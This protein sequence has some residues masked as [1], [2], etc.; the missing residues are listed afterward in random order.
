MKNIGL[1][2]LLFAANI[3]I[4]QNDLPIYDKVNFVKEMDAKNMGKNSLFIA[5]PFAKPQLSDIRD[6]DLAGKQ[7]KKI[8]Y[9][10]S[11]NNANPSFGQ[12]ELSNSRYK[13]LMSELSG[14]DLA[15]VE[16]ETKVQ[17]GCGTIP[18]SQKLDHGFIIEFEEESN[19]IQGQLGHHQLENQQKTIRANQANTIKG[20]EGTL[21]KIPENAFVDAFGN[22]VIGNVDINLKEALTTEAIVLANLATVTSNGEILQ[23]KGMIELTAHQNGNEVYVKEGKNIKV[24]VPTEFEEGYSYFEGEQK[25]G[26]L[27]WAN[28]VP[29]EKELNEEAVDNQV[30]VDLI[31]AQG[32]VEFVQNEM[33]ATSS[34][35]TNLKLIKVTVN[36]KGVGYDI[37][38]KSIKNRSFNEETF[39]KAEIDSIQ[40][41]F[42]NDFAPLGG[43]W[44]GR[45][46]FLMNKNANDM[47][48]VNLGGVSQD[49]ANTFRMKKLGWA[50]IDCLTRGNNVKKIRYN[51][52]QNTIDSLENFTISLVVPS[53]RTFIPGYEMKNGNYSFTH[54]DNEPMALMPVGEQAYIIAMGDKDGQTY[55]ELKQVKIGERTI[56]ELDLAKMN[57]DE[58]LDQIKK[59]L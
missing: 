29:I 34:S 2:L 41:W 43:G 1:A 54:G 4:A 38:E 27:V 33:V 14:A 6:Q 10:Y 40:S 11:N 9:L 17:V 22:E 46:D 3:T 19:S 47:V 42:D 48:G 5:S 32:Q 8:T 58:A 15:N 49:L 7:I 16:W 59:T 37:T 55:F 13:N 57:K 45:N 53:R 12:N 30:K 31:V 24:T 50:N 39:T 51:V 20:K 35:Y 28:P 56:E 26:N 52:A 36:K 44:Q 21:V 25:E 18:C 23:S